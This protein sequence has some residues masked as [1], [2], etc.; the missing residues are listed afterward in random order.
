[1]WERICARVILEKHGNVLLNERQLKILLEKAQE[2]LIE[3]PNLLQLPAPI[4][5][6]GDVGDFPSFLKIFESHGFP[7][8]TKYLFLGTYVRGNYG[9]AVFTFL[10]A[11]KISF[12][13][14]VYLLRGPHES[15]SLTGVY[16]FEDVLESCYGTRKLLKLFLPVFNSLPLA[17]IVAK[18]V[19]CLHGGLSPEL[20]SFGDLIKLNRFQEIPEQGL[21]CDLLWSRGEEFVANGFAPSNLGIGFNFG[22]AVTKKFLNQHGLKYIINSGRL[23]EISPWFTRFHGGRLNTIHSTPHFRH[24]ENLG[25]LVHVN[26][27]GNLKF[28]TFE[29]VLDNLD[30]F[31]L[32]R[33]QRYL[34]Q[35]DEIYDGRAQWNQSEMSQILI[36]QQKDEWEQ[37]KRSVE[38]ARRL[39]T[40]L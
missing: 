30:G 12:P 6:F 33:F 21:M 32:W 31:D 25:S 38:V 9:L 10:L 18:K 14:H 11:L 22:P 29:Q 17:A 28:E 26:K 16:G 37:H 3:E 8:K 1:V 4:T 39:N 24:R 5:V 34:P 20:H 2:I 15:R 23:P 13:Q 35:Y 19:F 40:F 27:K 36:K 7:P